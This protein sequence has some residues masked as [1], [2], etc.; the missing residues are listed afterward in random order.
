MKAATVIAA[1]RLSVRHLTMALLLALACLVLAPQPAVAEEG[2][3]Y[4]LEIPGQLIDVGGYRLHIYCRG[5]GQPVVIMDAGLG[6]SSYEWLDIQSSLAEHVKACIYDRAGYGW[7][8]PAPQP[9]TSGHIAEELLILLTSVNLPAPYVL[10]GHSFGGYNMQVFARRNP[11]LTAGLVLVDSSHPDQVERYLAPPIRVK[12]APEVN[13][14]RHTRVH[15]ARPKMHP[16]LPARLKGIVMAMLSH[17]VAR[18]AIAE[19]YVNFRQSARDVKSAPPMP[20]IPLF[21]ISRSQ[22]VW[23]EGEKGNRMEA[24]WLELQTELALQSP[25]HAHIIAGES[26]HHIH[27][28]QP[29]LVLAAIRN[30]IDAARLTRDPPPTY[31][32][33]KVPKRLVFKRAR[34]A[35]YTF[36]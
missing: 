6:D 22:R 21:V 7:S 20:D 12:L 35:S 28:D 23:P 11:E 27:L 17:G 10:V 36:N 30:V 25:R 24:L 3:P 15:L 14:G 32:A 19:E 26:G 31:Y 16:K 33:G 5:E 1:R 4:R 34:L 9:R 13:K 29:Q 8:E 2:S 18:R